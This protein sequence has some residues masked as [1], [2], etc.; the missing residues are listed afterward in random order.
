MNKREFVRRVGGASLGLLVSD[1]L[2][3]QYANVAPERLAED[4]VFWASIRGKFRLKPDC[5]N[6][7][8]GFFCLQPEEVLDALVTK[9]REINYEASYYMRTR[10]ADDKLS[11]RKRLATIAGCSPEELIITR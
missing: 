2:L 9:V 5:I 10:Q 6:L 11:V 4:E 8:N 1:R 3:A 7:E